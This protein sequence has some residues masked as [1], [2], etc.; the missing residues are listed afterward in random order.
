MRRKNGMRHS[1]ARVVVYEDEG[2]R[3]V[4]DGGFENFARMRKRFVDSTLRKFFELD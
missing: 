1:S 4:N 3:G 2:I